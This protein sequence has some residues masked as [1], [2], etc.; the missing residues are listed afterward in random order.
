MRNSMDSHAEAWER[1][2]S[3][4]AVTSM[5]ETKHVLYGQKFKI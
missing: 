2:N 5:L 4:G 1:G 3:L